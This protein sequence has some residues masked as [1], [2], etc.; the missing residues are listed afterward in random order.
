MSACRKY[1]Q[2]LLGFGFVEV[3]PIHEQSGVYALDR[4]GEVQQVQRQTVG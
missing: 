3:C 2:L 1:V 4:V